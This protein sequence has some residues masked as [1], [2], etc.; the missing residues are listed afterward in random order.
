MLCVA[1]T[2]LVGCGEVTDAFYPTAADAR[3]RGAVSAGWIPEWIPPAASSLRE[4][5][6]IDTNER[7]LAFDIPPGSWRAPAHYRPADG[8]EFVEPKFSRSW[9]PSRAVL[10]SKYKFFSCNDQLPPQMFQA[11]AVRADGAHVLQWTAYAR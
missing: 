9:L 7:A 2:L 3:A 6:D 4:V 10:T 11:L 5:H 1:C 8:G